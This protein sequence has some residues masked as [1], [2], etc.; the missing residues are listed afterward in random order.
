M[1]F[2]PGETYDCA[3]CAETHEVREG[4]GMAV[5]GFASRVSGAVYARCPVAGVVDLSDDDPAGETRDDWP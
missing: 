3:F 4:T 5:K 1:T 2:E